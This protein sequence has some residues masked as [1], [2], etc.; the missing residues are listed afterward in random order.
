MDFIEA[1]DLKKVADI[2]KN[3]QNDVMNSAILGHTRT[4]NTH[5]L[6]INVK[7]IN[8]IKQNLTEAGY[9]V[10]LTDG[11]TIDGLPYTLITLK[12]GK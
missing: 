8:R 4:Q 12:W 10:V 7:L 5:P 6:T 11:K 3:L 1:Q 9:E 2:I